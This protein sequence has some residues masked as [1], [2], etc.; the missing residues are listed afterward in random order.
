M[1]VLDGKTIVVGV[2]GGIAAYK[3]AELVRLLVTDG[4]KVRVMMT[5]NATEFI[6]PLTLQTLSLSPV[7]TDTFSLTQES[8]IGHIRMADTADAIVIAPA[9]ADVQ[10]QVFNLGGG[11]RVT[12]NQVL[13]TLE[14]ISNI[15]IR[16]QNLPAVTVLCSSATRARETLA[17]IASAL[18]PHSKLLIE[19]GLYAASAEELLDRLRRVPE[20]AESVMVIGHNPGLQDLAL[21]L[22]ANGAKRSRAME[23]F[24]TGALATLQIDV[25]R[26]RDLGPGDA[27]LVDYVV[28]R[29]L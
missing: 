20:P 24:P 21:T 11:S 16:R 8:E 15:K 23:D 2:T 13:A 10:G 9:T 12:V 26:W 19:D 27:E 18:G 29:E 25:A 17:L 3:A 4:A 22:A 1:G 14:E 28:P 5:R 7:A 6:T